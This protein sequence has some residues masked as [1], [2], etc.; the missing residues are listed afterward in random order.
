M[1]IRTRLKQLY[2]ALLPVKT[3]RV[4]SRK[5][6]RE[7]PIDKFRLSGSDNVARDFSDRMKYSGP[8]LSAYLGV[9]Q[10]M[11]MK[12]HHYLPVYEKILLPFQGKEISL[13]ELGVA[14]GGSLQMWRKFLGK[15][16][17]IYGIDINP[18]CQDRA[19]EYANVRIGSQAD[20]KF[21]AAVT[22]EMASLNVVIDDGSHNMEHIKSSFEILFPQLS[23]GGVYIVEDLHAAYWQSC[24][25][26]YNSKENFFSYVRDLTD[27]MHH[28]YH[29]RAEKKPGLGKFV[30]SITVYDSM[31]VIIKQTPQKPVW[32]AVPFT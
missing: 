25:G 13:L 9:E 19:K 10:D 20:A 18:S 32:S 1:S 31:C 29:N 5:L 2:R 23:D 16:A 21:L 12:W 22:S 26:G 28:H 24:G 8:L 3:R 15:E 30:Q 11:V 27:D 17:E 4:I 7:M 14:G 6:H